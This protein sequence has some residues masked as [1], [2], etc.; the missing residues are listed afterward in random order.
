M[1][2]PR[3]RGLLLL[4]G[5]TV[6]L[7]L[8]HFQGQ[9]FHSLAAQNTHAQSRANT[10]TVPEP[11]QAVV[12]NDAA[13]GRLSEQQD[14]SRNTERR[15]WEYYREQYPVE[16][17]VY[18]PN[19]RPGMLPKVQYD[20]PA[21]TEDQIQTRLKRRAAVTKAFERC[22]SSYKKYAWM[23]D[24]LMPLSGK[25]NDWY[26]GWAATL[27][28]SLDT[29]WIM[30]MKSEFEE[31]V[32]AVTNVDFSAGTGTIEIVNVFETNIRHLGGLIGAY[33][34]SGDK[35]LLE[36]AVELG[37][38]LYAA[39]DTPNRMPITRWNV[40]AR[41]RGRPQRADEAVLAAEIGSFGLE[42]TRLSQLTGNPKWFDAA[43]RIATKLHEAQSETYV[44]GMFPL[45]FNARNMTFDKRGVFKLGA[46]IDS[47]YEYFPKVY[48]L[49]GGSSSMMRDLYDSAARPAIKHTLFKPY[50]PNNADILIPGEI[51]VD[52]DGKFYP[53]LNGEHLGCY[54]GAMFAL[55]GKLTDNEHH[56]E[57]GEKLTHGCVWLYQHSP[58][59]LMPETFSM[60]P[61]PPSSSCAWSEEKWKEAV[62]R[63]NEIPFGGEIL[64]REIKRMALP[65]GFTAVRDK[66]YVLRPEAIES[67]FVLYR[68]TGDRKLLDAA[69]YMFS[70]I[71]RF[72]KTGKGNAGLDDVLVSRDPPKQ[73]RM[74]SFWMAETLKYF[75]L[76]FSEPDLISLDEYVL[77]TE[78][79]PFR[80]PT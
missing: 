12:A 52:E 72:T 4:A 3:R 14:S 53:R 40:K 19:G 49:L 28:D 59:G 6:V 34:L 43:N 27:I 55:G 24:E 32:A 15:P 61:C 46:M 69:W 29:L 8:L 62:M 25:G 76:I 75:Y 44:P 66:R 5:L 7:L 30:G 50:T 21:E 48:A 38:M 56:V 20:F 64:D 77:N 79:H 11:P 45:V 63:E 54:T 1:M 51:Y 71:E 78:A 13:S 73:D 39:F 42:F 47:L 17:F 70:A 26:G 22:W 60:Q 2:A 67:V 58:L 18:P 23:R 65:K 9:K 80:R 41:L 35:R 33:D 36:K 57:V 10:R 16:N 68:I 37:H 74:E 31:A